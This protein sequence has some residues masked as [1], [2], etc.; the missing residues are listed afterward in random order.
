MDVFTLLKKDHQK[1]K[2]LFQKL[3]ETGGEKT[4]QKLFKELAADLAV[5]SKAEEM[6]FYPRLQEFDEIRESVAEAIEE[7][8]A[9]EQLLEELAGTE[10]DEEQWSAKLVVLKEMVEHHIEEEEDELFSEAEDLLDE[11]EAAEMG[12]AIEQEKKEMLQG[13]HGAAK[14]VFARLGL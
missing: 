14:E 12:K 7:H 4:R 8:H 2:D 9:A 6:I 10:L 3:E 5:H 11:D 1:V 13:S